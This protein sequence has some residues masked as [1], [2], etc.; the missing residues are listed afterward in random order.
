MKISIQ[1]WLAMLVLSLSCFVI[2]TTELAPI[3]LISSLAGDLNQSEA[4]IGLIVTGYGW[5]AAVSALLSMLLFARISRKILLVVL[6]FGLALSSFM[7]AISDSLSTIFL[8]RAL[9]AIAHGAFWALIGGVTYSLVPK[10]KLGL[11]TSIIFSGVSIASALGIPLASFL[12]QISDWRV[13]FTAIGG[14][15]IITCLMLLCL[16]P[17]LPKTEVVSGKLLLKS[18]K[19]KKLNYIF[20]LTTLV[21]VCHFAAFT[22]I[23]PYLLNVIQLP[24]AELTWYLL[25]FG[26]FGFMGNILIG[27]FIDR[28]LMWIIVTAILSI[29]LVLLGMHWT[30]VEAGWPI[31]ILLSVWGTAIAILFVALQ[32]WMLKTA[33]QEAQ[34]A[35]AI[36]VAIFNASIGFGALLGGQLIEYGSFNLLYPLLAGI[37]L[38][39][40]IILGLAQRANQSLPRDSGTWG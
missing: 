6:M 32:T 27:R 25:C 15:S 22:F 12:N 11:A 29:V 14:L 39:G 5:L 19:N 34:S 37:L 30:H 7:V 9:G 13:V 33:Q 18:F 10:E 36:Y 23:T 2:V 4:N 3:G 40:L 26:L 1:I 20:A 16:V 28:Y 8:A 21:I 17:H 31:L 35:A 24:R 38:L